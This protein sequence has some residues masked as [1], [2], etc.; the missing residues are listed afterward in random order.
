MFNC[1]HGRS[2]AAGPGRRRDHGRSRSQPEGSRPGPGYVTVT[3]PT[4]P[5]RRLPVT[6]SDHPMIAARAGELVTAGA[7][8]GASP[9]TVGPGG[10]GSIH[11]PLRLA[12]FK[13]VPV[14]SLRQRT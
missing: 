4:G 3:G 7:G 8:P 6:D 14:T 11:C 10:D 9:S 2:A 1:G 12:A 5:A 13:E